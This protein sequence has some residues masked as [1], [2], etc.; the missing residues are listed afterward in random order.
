MKQD[1][2][3]TGILIGIAVLV[4]VALALFLTRTDNLE[5]VAEDTP[6]GVVQ[7]Y[8]VALYKKDYEKAYTYLSEGQ[9]KPS[10]EQFRD[11]FLMNYANP[12]QAGLEIGKT[13]SSGDTATVELGVIF[14]PSDPF[15]SGYRSTENAVLGRENGQWKLR[16]M[17]YQYWSYEW[18]QEPYNEVTP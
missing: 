5:Y 6:E 8:V 17:P 1:R 14:A 2:F 4:V 11:A 3:L 10:F 12:D 9:H 16:Q 15:S 7:N 13:N 18:Y